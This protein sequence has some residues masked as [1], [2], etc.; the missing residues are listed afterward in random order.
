MIARTNLILKQK[1]K[2]RLAAYKAA[3]DHSSSKED[4]SL[5]KIVEAKSEENS[6]SN[7]INIVPLETEKIIKLQDMSKINLIYSYSI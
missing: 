3:I 5:S 7:E 1:E 6:I 2:E 4:Q